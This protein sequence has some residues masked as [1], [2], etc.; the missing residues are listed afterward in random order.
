MND[1]KREIRRNLGRAQASCWRVLVS[2]NGLA[3]VA[4]AI[5][6]LTS[7]LPHSVGLTVSRSALQQG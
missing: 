2:I 1:D 4:F 3:F 6:L 7:C 5:L